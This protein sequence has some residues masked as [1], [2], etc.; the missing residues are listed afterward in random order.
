MVE[1]AALDRPQPERF[2]E[3]IRVLTKRFQPRDVLLTSRGGD[4]R[5]EWLHALIDLQ[6]GS[7]Q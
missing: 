5:D 7:G 1:L 4:G 2:H 6:R 3:L